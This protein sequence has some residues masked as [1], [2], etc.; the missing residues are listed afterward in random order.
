MVDQV[1]NLSN[2][3]MVNSECG[4]GTSFVLIE[5]RQERFLGNRHRA[6]GLHPLL[7]GFLLLEQ[8]SLS[9][10]IAAVA[11]GGHVLAMGLDG[12]TGDDLATDG[13]LQRYLEL[14]AV[15]LLSQLLQDHPTALLA[16]LAV[17]YQAQRLDRTGID[18]YLDLDQRVCTEL[19]DLVVHGSVAAGDGFQLV[20]EVVD[21]LGEWDLVGEHLASGGDEHLAS[22]D[23]A[24]GIAEH[25]E[26]ADVLVGADDLDLDDRFAYLR[27]VNDIGEIGGVVYLDDLAVRGRHLVGDGRCGLH[28]LDTTLAF[29]TLLDDL[30]VEQTEKTASIAESQCFRMLNLEGEGGVIELKLLDGFAQGLE[31]GLS[32]RALVAACGG[33]IEITE[34]HLL[35]FLVSGQRFLG[36]MGLVSD[37]V[38]D[39]NIG[40]RLD[41]RHHVADLIRLD[42]LGLLGLWS[43]AA[44]FGD[45]ERSTGPHHAD[46]VADRQ[47]A[48]EDSEVHDDTTIVVVVTVE[49]ERPCLLD[50]GLG[51]R[52]QFATDGI[53]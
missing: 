12:F 27:D 8:F 43:V 19:D 10:D 25:H 9:A 51:W 39:S 31:I 44:E 22:E 53:K 13:G 49:D 16:V 24:S 52:R 26:I 4:Q 42:P 1:I 2:R 40:K 48:V 50:L 37:G 36:K 28:D 15:D 17:A 45:G 35:W 5:N 11:F 41:R 34:D 29:K 23:A 47:R 32:A 20:V 14:M 6:D 30:H 3:L 33:W 38:A 21:D 7:A 46:L 18:E